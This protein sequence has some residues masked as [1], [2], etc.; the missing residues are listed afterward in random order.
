M[1]KAFLAVAVFIFCLS[2]IVHADETNKQD[3]EPKCRPCEANF[4]VDGSFFKGKTYKT[5]Q[6]YTGVDYDKT[7]R[8]VAQYLASN[9]WGTVNPNKEAGLISAQQQVIMG[10]GSTAPLN[11]VVKEKK[12]GII[13]VEAVFSTA[14]MQMASED[15]VREE[16]CKMVEAPGE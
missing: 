8:S 7:F 12:G 1:R 13:H 5:W 3:Q 14:G 10:H 16:L 11:I 2:G 6:E 15:T 9:G 4:S